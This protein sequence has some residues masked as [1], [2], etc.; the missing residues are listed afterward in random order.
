M[1]DLRPH[2]GIDRE[3]AVELIA[4]FG[5]EA[6]CEFALEHEDTDSGGRVRCKKFESEGRG[7]LALR[8]SDGKREKKVLK[9]FV[10]RNG[11]D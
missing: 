3:S 2:L 8:F 6:H 9:G 10:G 7:N 11:E 1:I 5:K 4:W